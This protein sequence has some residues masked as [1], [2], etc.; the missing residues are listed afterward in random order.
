MENRTL[1]KISFLVQYFIITLY[2]TITSSNLW[3][4]L[5]CV[6]IFEMIYV[7]EENK[8]K[9][10]LVMLSKQKRIEICLA[11]LLKIYLIIFIAKFSGIISL[12]IILIILEIIQNKMIDS[13]KNYIL[14]FSI[15]IIC[16][17]FGIL[18]IKYVNSIKIINININLKKLIKQ[19][20]IN[21]VEAIVFCVII[22]TIIEKNLNS[23]S[24]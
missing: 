10:K 18:F 8:S 9:K 13:S 14:I 6:I 15:N 7:V 2:F 21:M 11:E 3:F 5:L 16:L 23:H 1:D 19:T 12:N 22:I 17:L 4:I 24:K 20:I